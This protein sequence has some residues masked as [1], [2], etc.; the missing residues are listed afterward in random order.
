MKCFL[1]AQ[2]YGVKQLEEAIQLR[3]IVEN[4]LCIYDKMLRVASYSFNFIKF[5]G[6]L[7]GN[8]ERAVLIWKTYQM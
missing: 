4:P 7:F 3:Q 6:I 1:S 8:E 5:Q 2:S